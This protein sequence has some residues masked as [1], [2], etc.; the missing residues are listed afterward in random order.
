MDKVVHLGGQ[1]L[2]NSLLL[3]I[4]GGALHRAAHV[5]VVDESVGNASVPADVALFHRTQKHYRIKLLNELWVLKRYFKQHTPSERN[6]AILPQLW[7]EARSNT[8]IT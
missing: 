6:D 8:W 5:L 3:T 2:R 4:A 7:N 1:R